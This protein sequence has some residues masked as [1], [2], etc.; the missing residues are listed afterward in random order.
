MGSF[1]PTTLDIDGVE[2]DN[3]NAGASGTGLN[4]IRY[5]SYDDNNQNTI[6]ASFHN[7]FHVVYV[8]TGA[9]V[10]AIPML[11]NA[12]SGV[13][14]GVYLYDPDNGTWNNLRSMSFTQHGTGGNTFTV[15]ISA[16]GGAGTI[17]RTSGSMSYTVYV[18]RL[19]GGSS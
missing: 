2:F 3:F 15:Q 14:W 9:G 12:G 8:V 16:G 13:A 4:V 5:Y 17:Q 1:G 10:S 19:S 7:Q 6:G 11:P 18:S